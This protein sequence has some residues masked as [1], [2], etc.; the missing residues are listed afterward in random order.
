[1]GVP[2][3][4]GKEAVNIIQKI[5][6]LLREGRSCVIW[7]LNEELNKK[8]PVVP[9]VRHYEQLLADFNAVLKEPSDD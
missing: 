1:M 3:R 4:G 7:C 8:H 9:F 6:H 5:E 2:I